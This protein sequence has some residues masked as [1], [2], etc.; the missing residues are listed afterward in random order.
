M[1]ET[2]NRLSGSA[3]LLLTE[4]FNQRT[5]L[6]NQLESGAIS[7]R[8]YLEQCHYYFEK[9]GIRPF[10]P[11]ASTFEE[12]L[13]NYQ[14]HN[15]Y[16]KFYKMMIDESYTAAYAE[17]KTF[18]KKMD[19]HYL[20]K[21]RATQEMLELVDYINVEAYYLEMRSERLSGKLFEIVFTDRP[22][23]I[24]H[25]MDVRIQRKLKMQG[26]FLESPKRSLIDDYVN[27]K[28]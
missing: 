13:M 1:N 26:C 23:A 16:A 7:K 4:F 27:T 15:T 10:K 14:Y 18:E 9:R 2:D 20:Q 17:L 21:D 22:M 24:L 25:S 6:I 19:D 3:K 8:Y 11:R 5:N 28:Y 12:G